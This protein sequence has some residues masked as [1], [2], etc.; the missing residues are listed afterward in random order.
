[1]PRQPESCRSWQ[2]LDVMNL[3]A[4]DKPYR[5]ALLD[6]PQHLAAS[7]AACTAVAHST[8][9]PTDFTEALVRRMQAWYHFQRRIQSFLPKYLAA[10]ASDAFVEA[11]AF[12][13]RVWLHHEAPTFTVAAERKVGRL[14]PDVSV[15]YGK[16]LVAV[17][18]CKTNLGRSRQECENDFI[19]RD[20]AF[21]SLSTYPAVFLL[22]LTSKNWRGFG[23]DPRRGLQFFTL[24]NQWPSDIPLEDALPKYIV[25]PIEPMFRT[26]SQLQA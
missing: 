1:M 6:S 22:I 26:I 4:A 19:E 13:L 5:N 18:E 9:R 20:L 17:I 25:D 23:D 7:F 21:S 10:P 12:F 24:L 11:V 16:A 8:W 2:T 3:S 14:R 15:F